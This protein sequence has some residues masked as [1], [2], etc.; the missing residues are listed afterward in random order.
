MKTL[1]RF[2]LLGLVSSTLL[3][4]CGCATTESEN[5]AERPWGAPKGWETGLPSS[6]NQGR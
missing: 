2:A 4:L 6:F 1:L 3:L 5:R